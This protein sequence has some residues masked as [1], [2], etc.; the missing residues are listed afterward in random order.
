[1]ACPRESFKTAMTS[2]SFLKLDE[3]RS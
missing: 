2:Q 1:L 3:V